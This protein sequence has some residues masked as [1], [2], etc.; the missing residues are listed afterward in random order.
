MDR[1]FERSATGWFLLAAAALTWLAWTLLPHHL[2]TFFELGDFAAVAASFHLWIWLYRL[3]F[4]GLMV[5]V[6]AVV[7]LAVLVGESKGRIF[8]WP[9]AAVAATGIA[10]GAAGAAFY[11]H[12]AA[13]GALELMGRPP[14]ATLAF[15]ESVRYD[16]EYITC[17]TRFGRAFFGLGQLVL[18]A[19]LWLA[20]PVPRWLAAAG[21]VLGIAGM[22]LTMLLPDDLHLYAPIF[23]ANALW[24]AAM[25]VVLV[26]VRLDR[27]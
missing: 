23:H 15:I 4:V 3:Y 11:Y 13:W 22:A 19:G 1:D 25:G 12:H 9:G 14:E 26:R 17:L 8:A 5:T 27:S 2:G 6:M 18:A 10:V 24:L 16:T 21:A 7:A 20:R